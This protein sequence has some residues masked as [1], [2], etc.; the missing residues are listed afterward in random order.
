MAAFITGKKSFYDMNAFAEVNKDLLIELSG[1]S[2]TPSHDTFIRIFRV[3][4]K[5]IFALC[6]HK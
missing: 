1:V 6:L 2:A 3:L 5:K 4:D